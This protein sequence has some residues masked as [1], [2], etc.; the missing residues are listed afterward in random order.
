MT[1]IR[2]LPPEVEKMFMCYLIHE[3]RPVHTGKKVQLGRKGGWVHEIV[4]VCDICNNI[5]KESE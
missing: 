2:P 5:K 4:W 3:K 1:T